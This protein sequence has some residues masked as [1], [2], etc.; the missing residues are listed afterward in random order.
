M[1]PSCGHGGWVSLSSL[2]LMPWVSNPA[3]GPFPASNR[4]PIEQPLPYVI[5]VLFG[6]YSVKADVKEKDNTL[7][8]VRQYYSLT[9]TLEKNVSEHFT[10]FFQSVPQLC[11]SLISD[12]LR[13]LCS[14]L[15]HNK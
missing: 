13:T 3:L 8:N 1:A 9:N 7:C 6:A 4:L 10:P 14:R 12:D 5:Y 15:P 2:R 11:V